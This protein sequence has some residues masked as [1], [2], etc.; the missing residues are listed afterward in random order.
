[1]VIPVGGG[2]FAAW[3]WQLI[4]GALFDHQAELAG[5]QSQDQ[6]SP[7][8]RNLKVG[9]L[10]RLLVSVIWLSSSDGC[11]PPSLSQKN[12]HVTIRAL[13]E[14]RLVLISPGMEARRASISSF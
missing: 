10:T 11:I 13:K 3:G 12:S 2:F 14:G 5:T 6:I 4:V 9:T 8:A 7:D 1:M